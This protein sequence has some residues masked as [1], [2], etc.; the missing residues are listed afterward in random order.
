MF[1]IVSNPLLNNTLFQKIREYY[2]RNLSNNEHIGS[3]IFLIILIPVYLIFIFIRFDSGTTVNILLSGLIQGAFYALIAV[4]FSIIF[5]V[6]KM[7]KLSIG[8]YFVLGA[9]LAFWLN[10]VVYL[11][12]NGITQLGITDYTSFMFYFFLLK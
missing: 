6:S 9:Y 10:K 5:G 11:P 3:I 1:I 4:G 2:N 12:F 8:G 7:F